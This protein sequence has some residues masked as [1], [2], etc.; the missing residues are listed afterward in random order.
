M[1][2]LADNSTLKSYL[3]FWG[4]QLISLLGSSIV[5]FVIIV[6][7]TVETRSLIILSWANF[8]LL[9]PRLI[10]TPIAGVL[11][12]KYNRK[13]IILIADSTQAF[14][15]VVLIG[16]FMINFIN[17]AMIFSFISLRSV[18][19]SFHSPA[20]VAVKPSMVPK[21][22]LSRI[23][24]FEY[25]FIGLIQIFGAPIGGVLLTFFD[26]KYILW[27]D[28]ITFFIALIPL[29]LVKFPVLHINDK[30]TERKSF[31]KDFKTGV[32]VFR[33]I[34]GLMLILFISMFVNFLLQPLVVLM[35][36]YIHNLHGGS[37][38]L[39]G[40]IQM[41]FPAASLF[42]ALIPSFKKTWKNKFLVV[43]M[44]L[45]FVN[46]GYLVY[47]LAPI[48][49]FPI[50]ATGIII[51]GF[52]LPIINTIGMT[53]FQI[54]IPKDKIG[55][56]MSIILTLSMV[57]TP[58]GAIIAGPLSVIFGI[59]N[60][61]FY[62]ALIGIIIALVSYFFTNLRHIDYDQVIEINVE[63][64]VSQKDIKDLINK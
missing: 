7:I 23:N 60:L 3:F 36:Y 19:Q 55:R 16:F 18:C 58:L 45:I 64:E 50:I 32:K 8:F 21:E 38:L 44:G 15:T 39:L 22:K 26:I 29:I 25:L 20:A 57:I 31:L 33:A 30:T 63:K 51:I 14:L 43:C 61:Y 42:G 5:Q 12:D 35:P 2:E 9:F 53:I 34:P 28:V 56:V 48:G 24:G 41:L 54:V 62:C 52:V 40:F 37:V 6:W 11:S 13:K 1:E 17:L 10:F 59:T 46:I 49:F 4:G 47:A 27:V